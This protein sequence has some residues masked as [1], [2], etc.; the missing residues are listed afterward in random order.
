VTVRNNTCYF[1]NRDPKNTGIWRGE[2]SN[3]NSSN[4]VWVNNIGYADVQVNSYNRAILHASTNQT[5]NNVVW[6]R[7]LTFNGTAGS[8]SITQSPANA[9][10]TTASPY[11]NLL[12]VNP[13]FVAAGPNITTPDLH[14]QPTSP[15]RNIA[16]SRY[17]IGTVD[18]DGKRRT[19]GA[20]ADLGA[21]ELQ[22]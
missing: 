8:A 2:L 9:T 18:R 13:L 1:N 3:V 7:N 10:L 5:S 12:G 4:T 16:S 19:Y 6:S 22:G 21:Y 15:A 14:L 17:G 20:A 11:F